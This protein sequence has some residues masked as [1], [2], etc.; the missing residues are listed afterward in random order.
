MSLIIKSMDASH[1]KKIVFCGSDE[2]ALPMLDFLS[3]FSG[4]SIVGIITQPDRRMGRGRKLQANR[5][6]QWGGAREIE[7]RTPNK[8]GM[9]EVYWLKNTCVDLVLVMAY[10]HILKQNFLNAPSLGCFNLHASLLPSY[11]G[12]SPIETSLAS[13]DEKSGVTL[14]RMVKKMDAGPII[15]QV[16]VPLG[17]NENGI[18]LRSKLA[19]ACVPL[20]RTHLP[21]LIQGTAKETSQEEKNVTYCRK[22][23]KE[24]SFLDFSLSASQLDFRIRSFLSWPGST[25]SY[26]GISL[27]V[28]KCRVKTES[29]LMPGEILI[30]DNLDLKIGT[31]KGALQI[32]ELQKPGGKMLPVTDFLRGFP[33]KKSFKLSYSKAKALVSEKF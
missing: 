33:M 26:E 3:S 19:T 31:A 27:K 14:M 4:V 11:R 32:L 18:S 2:I 24:D 21:Q 28:G 22:L 23:T 29:E 13:G 20:L 5:I 8:P 17:I 15:G 9:E 1:S 16:D 30:K 7:V 6:K 25:F 10:G 12:A